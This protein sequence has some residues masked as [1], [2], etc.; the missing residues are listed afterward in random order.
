MIMMEGPDM[1]EPIISPCLE[2]ESVFQKT[3]HYGLPFGRF[4][5]LFYCCLMIADGAIGVI[6]LGEVQSIMTNKFLKSD[7]ILSPGESHAE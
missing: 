3:C 7:Y 1:D 5:Y 2:D 4:K 6:S